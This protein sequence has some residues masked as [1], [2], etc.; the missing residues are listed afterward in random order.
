MIPLIGFNY[1]K[2]DKIRVH[3]GIRYGMLYTLI[4]MALGLVGLNI[5][6]KQLIGIFTLSNTTKELCI[7]AIRIITLGYLFVGAN[8]AY[9]SIFQA[10]GCGMYSLIVSILRLI[11][12]A[13]PCAYE[14]SK[15]PNAQNI[16]WISFLIA[17]AGAF[18]IAVILMRRVKK[19]RLYNM[20]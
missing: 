15:L 12:I 4:I 20:E 17:E 19:I 14:L 18:V 5:F 2:R 16:I 8:I 9:Q 10:L 7:L 3:E 6:A 11:V 1:G 13:L